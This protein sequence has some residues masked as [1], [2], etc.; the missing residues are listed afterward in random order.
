[1]WKRDTCH[2]NRAPKNKCEK[3]RQGYWP[4]DKYMT[5]T[6]PKSKQQ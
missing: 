5:L 4:L 1:M 3:D 6:L 2:A